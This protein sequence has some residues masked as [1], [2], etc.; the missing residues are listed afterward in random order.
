[1]TP[2]RQ[3]IEISPFCLQGMNNNRVLF[4]LDRDLEFGGEG[5][6]VNFTNH[7]VFGEI[8]V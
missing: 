6:D 2:G 5:V 8:Q 1:V 4:S 3:A 7:R